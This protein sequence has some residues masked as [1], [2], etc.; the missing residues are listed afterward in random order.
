MMMK[1]LKLKKLSM[2]LTKM[3]EI[4]ESYIGEKVNKNVITV[5]QLI[6]MK[7]TSSELKIDGTSKILKNPK[8]LN[9]E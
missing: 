6:L 2:V 8:S 4:S 3:K 9:L 5:Y 1:H 7:S